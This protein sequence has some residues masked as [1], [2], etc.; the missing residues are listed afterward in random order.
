MDPATVL[1][2]LRWLQVLTAATVTLPK[3]AADLRELGWEIERMVNEKRGPSE[4]E[5]AALEAKLDRAH[6]ALARG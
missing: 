2:I 3:V 6:G 5:I 4:A 1:L